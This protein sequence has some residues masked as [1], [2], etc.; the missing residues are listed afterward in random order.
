[1]DYTK[2]SPELLHLS[3]NYNRAGHSGIRNDMGSL[4]IASDSLSRKPARAIIFLHCDE[5]SDFSGLVEHGIH[6]NRKKGAI[7]TAILPV[8][9]IDRLPEFEGVNRLESSRILHR[10]M[11]VASSGVHLDNSAN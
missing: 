7:R 1:M 5:N 10:Y 4:G 2:L 6:I 8:S 9:E 11:D 3:N